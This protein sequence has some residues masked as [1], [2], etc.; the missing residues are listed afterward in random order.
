MKYL[1]RKKTNI[2]LLFLNFLQI[3]NCTCISFSWQLWWSGLFLVS[4]CLVSLFLDTNR[5]VWQQNRRGSL[6][7]F[8]FLELQ[9]WQATFCLEYISYKSSLLNS[10][11]WNCKDCISKD[12]LRL[13]M[14]SQN[15][16]GTL[17]LPI[18]ILSDTELEP[19]V[20]TDTYKKK[21]A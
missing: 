11:P 8:P 1:E 9:L 10:I 12:I 7:H 2:F 19:K 18:A 14:I 13:I 21:F 3:S 5:K 17:S 15:T 4:L 16:E 6:F 20:V